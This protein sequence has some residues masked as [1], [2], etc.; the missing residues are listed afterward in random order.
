MRCLQ[1][2][3]VATSVGIYNDCQNDSEWGCVADDSNFK[4]KLE[5]VIRNRELFTPRKYF[6]NKGYSTN[7]CKQSWIQLLHNL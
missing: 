5:Y 3:I 6:I 4:D 7:S 2:P 1:Y